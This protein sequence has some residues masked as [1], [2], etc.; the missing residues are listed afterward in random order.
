DVIH[1]ARRSVQFVEFGEGAT[2]VSLVCEDLAQSD[3]VADVLRAVGPTVVVTPLLDGPQLSSRWAARYASVFADDP[4]STVLTLTSFGMARRSRPY[5]RNSSAV[6]ALWKD[7]GRGIREVTLEAGAQGVLI[8]ASADRATRRSSDG[9][10]PVENGT[11][12]FD[13]SVYQ[14]QASTAG[15]SPRDSR[16]ASP[17]QNLLEAEELTILTSWA[18]AV[19]EELTFAPERIAATLAEANSVAPLRKAIGIP[20]PSTQLDQAIDSIDEAIR[21]AMLTGGTPTPSAVVAAIR[22]NQPSERRL[23]RLARRVLRSAL[24]QRQTRQALCDDLFSYSSTP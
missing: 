2:L 4:G 23:D 22:D 16:P 12:L 17:P 8:S 20:E 24:E 21:T 15:S 10:W 18:E 19:A 14:V 7:P 3:D 5:G 13:M 9:R 6:I 1:V 11:E